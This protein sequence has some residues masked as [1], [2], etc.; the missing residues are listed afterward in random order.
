[1]NKQVELIRVEI[2][3][4]KGWANAPFTTNV[5]VNCVDIL[6]NLLS[7]ID[8]MQEREPFLI[9]EDAIDAYIS[10]ENK[11][12]EDLYIDRNSYE[13]KHIIKLKIEKYE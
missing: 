4:L 8:S 6:N 2:E 10:P 1:M 3:R 7:F 13:T 11:D 9:L 12:Y 5:K